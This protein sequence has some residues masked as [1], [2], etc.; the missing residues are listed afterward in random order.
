M[1]VPVPVPV[2]A[3][4]VLAAAGVSLLLVGSAALWLHGAPIPVADADVVP[5]PG[6]Q[7]LR[8]LREALAQMACPYASSQLSAEPSEVDL[9]HCRWACLLCVDTGSSMSKGRP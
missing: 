8:Q 4:A 1:P 7:N 3:A 6:K 5:E 9:A 2:L